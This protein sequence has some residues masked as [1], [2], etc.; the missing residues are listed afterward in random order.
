MDLSQVAVDMPAVR[1]WSWT[2]AYATAAV[3]LWITRRPSAAGPPRPSAPGIAIALGALA[4]AWVWPQGLG[5][6]Q[7]GDRGIVLRFGAPTGTVLG[8]GLYYVIPLADVVV[9]MNAQI[10]TITLDRA[11]GTCSDLEP[12]YADLAVS[13]H[14][15]PARAIDVY[16]RLRFDYA[17]RVVYPSV[18][19]AWKT[20]VATYRAGDLVAKR[21][22]IMREFRADLAGRLAVF[23][24]G[25]DALNT[26]RI[27]Y[28]YAYQQAAQDK[29]AAVQHTLQAEQDL[30]RMRFESQQTV[31]RARSEVEA[32][33]LQ[34]S[35]PAAL[36]IEQRRLDLQ[37][38]AIDK[39]DGHLPQSTQGIPFL[40]Q[41]LG[42]RPD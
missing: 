34:R 40:S 33:K 24:L 28:S 39:W 25:L 1:F 3:A 13:F 36:I 11:Q 23:G 29:V 42:A 31:I 7:P 5:R 2:G 19:D 27:N 17:T 35:V 9:Q 15:I 10:N 38:R 6:V 8:E 16:R 4:L 22:Q 41:Q 18:Q 37:R 30:Q 20:T 14:V 32:L 12:V 26:T 21:P